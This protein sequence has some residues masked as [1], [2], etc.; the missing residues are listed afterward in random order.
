MADIL[1]GVIFEKKLF[2]GSIY[3]AKTS[4]IY[5]DRYR[6][7]ADF[8]FVHPK[9]LLK[10]QISQFN[11]SLTLQLNSPELIWFE[12]CIFIDLGLHKMGENTITFFSATMEGRYMGRNYYPD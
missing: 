7:Y 4:C 10:R 1:S 11:N 12:N 6:I 5:A 2:V 3:N 8:K 9:F